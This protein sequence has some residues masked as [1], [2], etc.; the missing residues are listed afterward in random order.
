MGCTFQYGCAV[1]KVHLPILQKDMRFM[2][3]SDPALAV[4]EDVNWD[5]LRYVIAVIETGTVSGAARQLGVNHATVLRRI[6]SFEAGY[7][8]QIFEK[9]ARGYQVLPE[10]LPV[11]E[12]LRGVSQAMAFLGSSMNARN[13]RM[14]Q[15]LRLTSTDTICTSFLPDVLAKVAEDEP[16]LRLSVVSSNERID[17]GRARV[18]LAVRPAERLPEDLS[19]K[20]VGYMPF[21]VYGAVAAPQPWIGLRGD[22]AKST[23]GRAIE[24]LIGEAPLRTVCDTFLVGRQLACNGM[25]QVVLPCFI[26]EAA[27]GLQRKS[28]EGSLPRIPIWLACHAELAD[29]PRV[30]ALFHTVHR[31]L[32]AV[33]AQQSGLMPSRSGKA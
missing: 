19:G 6:A 1:L 14:Q 21:A 27:E 20:L 2:H 28:S 11:I 25:G 22:L 18:D 15:A 12:A 26:G 17:L 32:V 16:D 31:A 13:H 3:S 5:D 9:S 8:A 30:K 23:I 7:N 4:P 33:I 29:A 10:F 24:D